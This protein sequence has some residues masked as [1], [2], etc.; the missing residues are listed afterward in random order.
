VATGSTAHTVP[1][2]SGV[3]TSGVGAPGAATATSRSSTDAPTSSSA[4]GASPGSS[5][6]P[7]TTSSGPSGT[8][9]ANIAGASSVPAGT[10]PVVC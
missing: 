7:T 8:S 6:A 5:D 1:V 10:R 4:R 3:A 9:S 2:P